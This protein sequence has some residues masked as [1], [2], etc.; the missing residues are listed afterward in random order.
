VFAHPQ[1]HP[2]PSQPPLRPAGA[3]F[4]D[5]SSFVARTGARQAALYAHWNISDCSFPV[6]IENPKL[7]PWLPLLNAVVDPSAPNQLC[8]DQHELEFYFLRAFT[9]TVPLVLVVVT[10]GGFVHPARLNDAFEA[11]VTV[12]L[13]LTLDAE[14]TA[15]SGIGPTVS[16]SRIAAAVARLSSFLELSIAEIIPTVPPT[17]PV[18]HPCGHVAFL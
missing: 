6:R 1:L 4:D 15:R 18:G 10:G 7:Q 3:W 17:G 2:Q 16:L 8:L 9:A 12:G 13:D 5:R 11:L 14:I